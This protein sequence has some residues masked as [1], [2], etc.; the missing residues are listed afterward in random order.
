MDYKIKIKDA[1]TAAV[2]EINQTLSHDRQISTDPDAPLYGPQG[3]VDSLTLTLL[4][5]AI[6]QKIEQTLSVSV[7]LIDYS[8]G[9]G[10]QNPFSSI[11][12]LSDHIVALMSS[13][14][15]AE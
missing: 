15:Y 6:E 10:E 3:V 9:L 5:V 2:I 14:N 11:H 7:T 4:I 12:A 1:I 8:M 13:R